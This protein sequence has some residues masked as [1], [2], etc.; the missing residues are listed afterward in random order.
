MPRKPPAPYTRFS[1]EIFNAI[2]EA[3]ADGKSVR[4]ACLPDEMPDRTIFNKW[5]KSSPELQAQYDK[6]C[7][8]RE[9]AIFDDAQYIAD[10]EKDAS[11]ARVRVDVRKWRLAIMNR[12]VYGDKLGV[13]GGKDGSPITVQIIRHGDES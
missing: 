8:E 6:A 1:Q 11:V 5:R 2:C 10:T 3:V 13:D 7:L 4:E 12:K 9:E